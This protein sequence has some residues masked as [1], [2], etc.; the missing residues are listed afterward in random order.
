MRIEKIEADKNRDALLL[1]KRTFMQ[2][3]AADFSEKGVSSFMKILDDKDFINEIEMLGAYINSDL[4]GM[5]AT[6]NN[7]KHITLFFVD[8][9]YHRQGIGK[10]LFNRVLQ[11]NNNDKITVNSSPY[12]VSVYLHLGFAA[13]CEECLADGIRYVPM[14]YTKEAVIE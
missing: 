8:S 1:I 7:R 3:E 10:A 5:I 6:R 2:Y 9:N 13:D 14:T 11:N 4:V 12:A